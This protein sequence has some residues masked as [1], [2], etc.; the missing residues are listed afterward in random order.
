MQTQII[1]GIAIA[2]VAAIV[3][4]HVLR[5]MKGSLKLTI[6]RS[7][8]NSGELLTGTVTLE[9]KKATS[10]LLKVSLVGHERRR[11]RSSSMRPV[12]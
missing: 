1:I 12:V 5:Y 7:T 2:I 3:G 11:T 6:G 8:A 10:G 9:I 4:Y